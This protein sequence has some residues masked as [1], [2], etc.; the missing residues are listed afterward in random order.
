VAGD[1]VDLICE[2]KGIFFEP[3]AITRLGGDPSCVGVGRRLGHAFDPSN[4][5]PTGP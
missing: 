4:V 2:R 3:D 5:L 1:P